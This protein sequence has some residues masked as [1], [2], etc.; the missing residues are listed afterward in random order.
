MHCVVKDGNQEPK[1]LSTS[2]KLQISFFYRCQHVFLTVA[3]CK[4]MTSNSCVKAAGNLQQGVMVD[5][6]KWYNVWLHF[7]KK[8]DNSARCNVCKIIIS[9]WVFPSGVECALLR[10]NITITLHCTGR[11]ADFFFDKENLNENKFC[12]K[13][14]SSSQV[15]TTVWRRLSI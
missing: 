15:I 13:N 11:L 10:V 3:H 5:R 12:T 4:T 7:M 2:C 8:D 1:L 6:E 9:I 14:V